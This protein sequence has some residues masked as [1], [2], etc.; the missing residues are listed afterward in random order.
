[1]AA[2]P[3]YFNI[4]NLGRVVISAANTNRDGNGTTYVVI[5]AGASGTLVDRACVTAQG[6]TSVGVVRLY[7]YDGATYTLFKEFL[8]PAIT[9][10]TTVAVYEA[11]CY[12]DTPLILPSGWSIKA[13]THIAESFNVEAFGADA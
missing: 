8:I 7:L 10:S 6:T 3:K 12:W 5:A 11:T 4:P 9:P 13:S 1:M 2:A